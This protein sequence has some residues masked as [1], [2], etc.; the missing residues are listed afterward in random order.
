MI[1]IPRECIEKE[2]KGATKPSYALGI[3]TKD[4]KLVDGHI[5]G[6]EQSTIP[7]EK[8]YFE[9]G[10]TTKTFTGLLLA[11]LALDGVLDLDEPIASYKPEYK[12]ALT[13][14]GKEVTF[15]HLVTHS[16]GL[17]REDVK[18][19]R[20]IM[21]ADKQKKVNIFYYYT[22]EHFHQFYLQHDLKREIGK[23]W[24]YSNIGVG[25]LGRVLSEIVGMEY[26]DAIKTHLLNPLG[27]HDTFIMPN[28]EQRQRYVQAYNNKGEELPPLSFSSLQAAGAI[29]STITDMMIY[30]E[31][32]LGL[33]ESPLA[34][35]IKLTHQ[36][37]NVKIMKN[38]KMGLSWFIEQKK[39]FDYPIIHHGGTT[40]GFHTYFGFIK[41]LQIGVVM[42]S[43]I[44][45]S[46][47]RIIKML[48]K[49]ADGVNESVALSIFD[50]Y[51]EKMPS[52]NKL[53]KLS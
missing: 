25:L 34:D 15:R 49:L 43:T 4:G 33:R 29:R 8:C 10:S 39:G 42:F 21:K 5:Y 6:D 38:M 17:P 51:I 3:V 14:Q 45:L 50:Q 18:K 20:K 27:M 52:N 53:Q 13:Y 2:L 35:A 24:G 19:I 12:N 36:D 1:Q 47:W 11:K 7:V 31:H 9:I 23:K 37:Q 28:E 40:F 44:Q 41:E 26:E 46:A 48:L 30:L 32:Q 16:S 22:Y